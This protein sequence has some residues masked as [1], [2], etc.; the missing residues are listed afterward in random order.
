MRSKYEK[1]AEKELKDEGWV[2]DNKAGGSYWM[3]NKD[4]FHLFD[5]VAVKK[6]NPIRWIAIKGHDGGSSKELRDK[7]RKFWMPKNN[8]KELWYMAKKVSRTQT[9]EEWIKIDLSSVDA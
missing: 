8:K 4:Y 2:V 7:I 1:L 6:N 9:I 5:L 3:K